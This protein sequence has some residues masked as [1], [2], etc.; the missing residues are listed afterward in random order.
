[1][2][3][4]FAVCIIV[5]FL[6]VS[7]Y[8]IIKPNISQFDLAEPLYTASDFESIEMNI[9]NL[10]TMGRLSFVTAAVINSSEYYIYYDLYILEHRMSGQWV[11]IPFN[12]ARLLIGGGIIFPSER[13]DFR[14]DLLNHPPIASWTIS[15]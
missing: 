2:K 5:A 4:I 15:Y 3:K 7:A 11:Q 12:S 14:I 13:S 9:T 10:N 1:M 8:V 6:L